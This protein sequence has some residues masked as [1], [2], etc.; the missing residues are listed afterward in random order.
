M[1]KIFIIVGLLLFFPINAFASECTQE[2]IDSYLPQANQAS[3]TY[4]VTTNP[5]TYMIYVNG[6]TSGISFNGI[7]GVAFDNGFYAYAQAGETFTISIRISDGSVCSLQ[8]IKKTSVKLPS[9]AQEIETESEPVESNEEKPEEEPKETTNDSPKTEASPSP[10]P[11]PPVTTNPDIIDNS[12]NEEAKEELEYIEDEKELI[13]ED[14]VED[15]AL[16]EDSEKQ[17]IAESISDIKKIPYL[18]LIP[19]ISI[20]GS[21]IFIIYKRRKLD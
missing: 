4:Q 11:K 19:I 10:K 6:L 7:N 9:N 2:M 1:K 13:S 12:E 15:I 8:E 20:I 5:D 17:K 16:E 3:L 18:I 14:Q 21:I